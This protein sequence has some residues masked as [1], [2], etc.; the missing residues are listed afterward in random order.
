M[1]FFRTLLA[2]FLFVTC[3]RA[4][5]A[6]KPAPPPHIIFILADDLGAGD[7]GCY[8]GTTGVPTPNI[9]RLAREGIRFTQ[10]YSASPICSRRVSLRRCPTCGCSSRSTEPMRRR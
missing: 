4:A 5:E 8:G 10:Y 2:L 6:P 9:D 1:H 3:L 7:I